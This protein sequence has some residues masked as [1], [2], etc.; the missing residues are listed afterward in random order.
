MNNTNN[1]DSSSVAGK[2]Q[3]IL[4]TISVRH[5]TFLDSLTPYPTYRWVASAVLLIA[6]ILRFILAQGW[7]IIAYGLG[8]YLLNAFLAFLTPR[9][10]PALEEMEQEE[11]DNE[12]G[13]SLPTRSDDEFRPFIRRLPEFKFWLLSTRAIIISLF[14]TLFNALDIPVFWPILLFYFIFLFILTMRRQIQHMIKHRYIPF[15]LGKKNYSKRSG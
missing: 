6:F 15:D 5:Q 10:D 8:I 9:F 4:H 2:L 3:K 14:C 13:F 12:S 7:Y 11:L 1:E